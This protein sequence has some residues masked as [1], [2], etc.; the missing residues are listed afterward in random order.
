MNTAYKLAMIKLITA[1]PAASLK[2]ILVEVNIHI[3]KPILL[4]MIRFVIE[5]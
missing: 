2:K 1:A 3:T 4:L 5:T